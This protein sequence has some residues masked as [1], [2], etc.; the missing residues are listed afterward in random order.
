[1]LD[2]TT[3][4]ATYLWQDHSTDPTFQVTQQGSYWVEVTTANCSATDT[5]EVT[6]IPLPIIDLGNDTT[7]CQGETVM[8]DATTA[9]ATYLW[10]DNSTD[11]TFQVT[12][13]G[14]YWVEVTTIICSATDTINVTVHPL[15]IIDL[16]NDTTICQGETVM[17]DATTPNATYLWQDHSTDPTFQVTQQG[18]YW[19]KVTTANCSA[20]DTIEVAVN[21]LPIIDLGSDTTIC[22]G[23]TV[24]LDATT[25]NATYLWQDNST[26]PTIQVTQQGSYW[27]EVT[28]A[29]C[30]VTDNIVITEED[31]EIILE[32]PNVFSPNND[33]INDVFMPI[34]NQGIAS[35]KTII[36]NRWGNKLFET[37]HLL[38]EWDGQDASDGTYFWMINY[39]GINRK[40][41][42]KKG[43]LTLLR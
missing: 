42:S 4:N 43:V 17:L 35:M 18:S 25:T 14:S 8:L 34:T 33:G 40:N 26:N 9:N 22:H 12:Q 31:C 32:L 36:Y 11:P 7:I 20:T 23:Q 24:M 3:P 15:S 39:V 6:V 2:A 19:V 29:N 13:Q 16:G 10:Q 28:T 5:I 21:P 1:M 41:F 37:D 27:V 38:I 30:S